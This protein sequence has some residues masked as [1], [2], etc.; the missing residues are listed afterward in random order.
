M[1]PAGTPQP[2]I[3]RVHKALLKAMENS[4]VRGKLLAQGAETES[5][6]PEELREFMRN[7]IAKWAKAIKLAGVKMN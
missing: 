6:T 2:I 5:S 7:D 1:A 4:D 3:Q